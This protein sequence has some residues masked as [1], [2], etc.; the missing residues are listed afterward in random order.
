[1]EQQTFDSLNIA[2]QYL[3]AGLSILP[4]ADGTKRPD[5]SLLPTVW[6]EERQKTVPTWR[7][8]QERQAY[9][10]EVERWFQRGTA[11]IGII[12]GAVSGG[13]V[14]ID[15]ES[16][17]AF[18]SWSA[19]ARAL[20]GDEVVSSLPVVATGKGRHVYFRMA[21]PI[22]NRKL[23][24]A[25]KSV[26]AETRGEGGYVLA[27][28]SVHPSGAIYTLISGDLAQIPLVSPETALALLDAARALAPR[29]EHPAGRP[30]SER[31][32]ESVIEAFNK[33]RSIESILEAGGYT[34]DRTGRYIRPGGNS[35]TVAIVGGR[36]V[37]YN[38]ND[39]LHSESPGGGVYSHSPFSA[40]CILQHQGDVKAAV[41]AAAAELGMAHE[42]K[43]PKDDHQ[44]LASAG[45]AL[46]LGQQAETDAAAGADTW[47]YFVHQGGMWMHR[48]DKDG[49]PKLP[50]LLTNWT[51]QITAEVTLNDGETVEERYAL[52]AACGKRQRRLEMTRA[53]FEGESAVGRL[54][55]AL[56]AK[57][58]V[59]PVAQARYIV[60]AIKAFS[61]T[62][63]EHVM[64]THLGWVEDRYLVGNGYVDREGWHPAT[65]DTASRAHLPPRLDRYRLTPPADTTIAD[66]LAVFGDMLELAPPSV[67]VPLV[68]AVLLAPIA[69]LLES[70]AP[71]V[72]ING[73]TG[74]HKT[75]ICCAALSLFGDFASGQPT[76]TWT[77]TAN[78][79]QKLGW[80][81]KDAPM[82]LDDYKAKNVKDNAVVFLLQNYGDNMAR[83]RLDSEANIK[84]AYPIRGVLI[85]SGE[86]QPEGEAS[87]LA[88]ILTV[89]LARGAVHR[90]KLTRI[91]SEGLHLHSL[92]IAYLQWL[93]SNPQPGT[94]ELHQAT[95]NAVLGRLEQTEHA[96]NPG[97]VASNVATLHVAWELLMR[98]LVAGGHWPEAHAGEWLKVCKRELVNLAKRQLDLTTNERYSQL[99][100]EALR[101]LLASGKVCLLQA[102]SGSA[103][104]GAT[105][106]GYHGENGV[107]VIAQA[108]YDEVAK[109][110]RAAGRQI[111]YSLRA[112][113]QMLE[114][115]GL[116]VSTAPPSLV[117]RRRLNGAPVWCWHLP[118]GLLD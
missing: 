33:A 27:P 115:D 53:E 98:F 37:H 79:V 60:D 89:D 48:A 25:G 8:F 101:A 18:D 61:V 118:S 38:T 113:S 23:A 13:L 108:A 6:D 95:R 10:R 59:N 41:R 110:G 96:T 68:G 94:R 75:S 16:V 50:L 31:G 76:D 78:S 63:E 106:I 90:G 39:P 66:A 55:A 32:G 43:E 72:H 104:P 83:G 17:E 84:S 99:F 51:A 116:L 40:W 111:G 44:L 2:L 102:S 1:M 87:T 7:P 42:P 73:P 29:E 14:V 82:V 109:T 105:P 54:V 74:S 69:P 30:A 70:P 49:A 112:L 62:P 77:S 81:L 45:R 86:D 15:I 67:M 91:Q 21:N 20:A 85:S 34:R 57:A 11:G 107:F 36:S 93:A 47:P 3:A 35:G 97:R 71:M 64:Y 56:G 80:H 52:V 92:T 4:I 22:G 88:R 12:G 46:G 5:D 26:L 103:E 28:P 24:T 19:N 9:R 65:G 114:Q 100:L 117:V 58:R